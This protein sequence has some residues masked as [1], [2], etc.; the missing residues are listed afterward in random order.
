M[1]DSDDDKRDVKKSGKRLT[2]KMIGDALS[3]LARTGDGMS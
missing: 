3:V 1:S 2:R